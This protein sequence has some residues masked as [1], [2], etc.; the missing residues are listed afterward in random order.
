MNSTERFSTGYAEL[1]HILDG[2][3]I[4][5]NVIFK[6]ESLA[7]YRLFVEPFAG[8][9]FPDQ[10]RLSYIRFGEHPPLLEETAECDVHLLDPRMG[11]EFFTRSIYNI[12]TEQGQSAYYVFDCLSD[13]VSAWATD[14][15]IANFLQA[16]CPCLSQIGT[17]AYFTIIRDHHSF[18][19]I[20]RVR[21]ASQVLIDCFSHD[22]DLYI[23]PLK[24]RGDHSPTMFL[25]HRK[26]GCNFLPLSNSIEATALYSSL[27]RRTKNA[28]RRQVD[29]WHRIFLAAEELC[30]SEASVAEQEEVL[31]ELCQHMIA[32][33]EPMLSL[34]KCYFTLDA[35]LEIK[36]R[37]VGTGFIGGKAAGMLMAQ[38][39]LRSEPSFDWSE[40]LEAHDSHYVGSNVYYTYL[41]YNDLWRLYMEQKTDEGYFTAAA[42][43]RERIATGRFPELIRDG[44]R[45][46][47]DYFG[48]FPIIVR[49]SSLLEDSFGSAFAGKYDSFFCVNQGSPEDR[50]LQLEDVVRRIFASTMSDDALSYRRQRV[51]DQQDEQMALLVQRVSG[52]YRNGYYLPELAG[53]GV[54]YN[55]FVWDNEMEPQAGM[56]RLVIG[57][58]TRAVGRAADDYPRVVALDAPQKR[59]HKGADDVRRFSQHDVDL[60]NVGENRFET[61]PLA[62][63]I[64]EGCDI[65]WHLYAIRD[66]A[67]MRLLEQRGRRKRDIWLLTFDD[68]LTNTN[69]THLLQRLL[70]TLER[71]YRYPVDVE[72]T[73]N[74]TSDR[75]VKIDV[76]QCRPLQ[77]KGVQRRVEM[78]EDIASDK[79][80]FKSHGHFMGGN[81][82]QPLDWVI[83]IEAA[84]YLALKTAE[85]YTVSRIVGELNHLI[86]ERQDNRSMLIGPGRWG[87]STP[88][89][90]VP[91]SFSRINHLT[92]LVEVAFP[93]G[94]LMPELSYGSH[95][96]QD[97]VE[98]DIFYLAL[99]PD[100]Q[101]CVLN[102][103]WLQ[104]D[105][106]LQEFDAGYGQ[107]NQVIKVIRCPQGEL[108]LLAD[109]VSQE[110]VCFS[111]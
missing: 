24:V 19:T 106:L 35:L 67:T 32:R 94:N 42:E 58:G 23:Q 8:Q 95:F 108:K 84:E 3:R 98:A 66:L 17:V 33:E 101:G 53:V 18:A 37:M 9:R 91:I 59:Q 82:C 99:F 63:L 92:V 25:P 93:A 96:F 20:E 13:L 72:F 65:P 62:R 14:H 29:H 26:N 10:R 43:L 30:R 105:N 88:S 69:F 57:L 5:D 7:D 70:K 110:L 11:F 46:L 36:S 111:E 50:L 45:K 2:L 52:A 77:T 109:I 21:S 27:A 12:A 48:T 64:D 56:L 60:L 51:L 90:G 34:V 61:V 4:G 78:P 39:I 44:F 6:V 38:N 47:L 40:H 76:V 86:G 28:S 80:F 89:L 41:I 87:T 71:A 100:Q 74:F 83:W 31:E 102:H 107:F 81:L 68:F 85:K 103:S 79:L 73:V 15:M 22:E 49:S 97:L 54:S 104:R 75:T 16:I 1:D 55:T